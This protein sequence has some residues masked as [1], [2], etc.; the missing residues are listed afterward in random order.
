ME[1]DKD[2]QAAMAKM[3]DDT[4]LDMDIHIGNLIVSEKECRSNAMTLNARAD[5][6]A[7]D[8][9]MM[10]HVLEKWMKKRKDIMGTI[11]GG[12]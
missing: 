5:Q 12:K 8:R 3:I 6:L 11:I 7:T 2:K 10:E 9:N 4:I 1:N